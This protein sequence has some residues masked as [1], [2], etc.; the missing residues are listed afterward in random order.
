LHDPTIED[1]VQNRNDQCRSYHM[2][3]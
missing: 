3:S 1:E 2:L